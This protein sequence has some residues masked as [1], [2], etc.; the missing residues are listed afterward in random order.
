[1]SS[2]PIN[3]NLKSFTSIFYLLLACSL[4]MLQGCVSVPLQNGET[5]KQIDVPRAANFIYHLGNITQVS[6][7]EY[8]GAKTENSPCGEKLTISEA[9]GLVDTVSDLTVLALQGSV[10]GDQCIGTVEN[11]SDEVDSRLRGND[12]SRRRPEEAGQEPGAPS[13][14][15]AVDDLSS[16]VDSRLRGNDESRRR[17]D[18]PAQDFEEAGQDPGAPGSDVAV[19]DDI[20]PEPTPPE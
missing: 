11:L 9:V 14:D 18:E 5:A 4:V 8:M 12:K 3:Q 6:T 20:D 13:S 15:V 1:M 2:I 16:E 7:R 19:D 17:P 10:T